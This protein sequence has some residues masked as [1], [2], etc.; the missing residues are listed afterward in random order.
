LIAFAGPQIA[1]PT[2]CESI[3]LIRPASIIVLLVSIF[4]CIGR[5]SAQSLMSEWPRVAGMESWS[6]PS[7]APV[8][9]RLPLLSTH[10][11]PMVKPTSGPGPVAPMAPPL[12]SGSPWTLAPGP[13][14]APEPVAPAPTPSKAPAAPSPSAD[15]KKPEGDKK[16]PAEEKGKKKEEEIKGDL[17]PTMIEEVVIERAPWYHMDLS[18]L[19]PWKGNFEM[20]MD[21]SGGNTD[22]FNIRLGANGK[23]KTEHHSLTLDLDYHKNYNDSVET[24]NRMNFQGRYE[25]LA[26]KTPWTW[27]AQQSTDYDEFQ[28]WDVRVVG[29]VGLGYRL[30]D[31]EKTK[32]TIRWG[33]GCSQR[34]GGP[35]QDCVP[36]MNHGI[37]YEHRMT[38]RQKIKA[39]AEYFPDVTAWE[40]CRVVSKASWEVLLDAEN[41]LSLKLSASDRYNRPNPGG[42]LNDIDYAMVL[43]WGF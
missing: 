14:L 7:V 1:H 21:G 30:F 16:K 18:R 11:L 37:E 15:A 5:A 27:F 28:P 9:S 36:E 39:S 4:G 6:Q 41:N 3:V 8:P 20:G 24:A 43:I 25:R 23:L 35:D 12:G 29:S 42:K 32:L 17:I 2:G 10:R 33:A 31:T 13:A 40:E 34:I 26:V 38:K 22:T 19:H